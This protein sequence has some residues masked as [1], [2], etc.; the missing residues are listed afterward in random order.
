MRLHS[1][2]R[3]VLYFAIT[4]AMSNCSF[5]NK[6]TVTEPS[7]SLSSTDSTTTTTTTTTVT[8]TSSTTTTTVPVVISGPLP[9]QNA[10]SVSITIPSTTFS[11]PFYVGTSGTPTIRVSG[12]NAGNRVRLYIW[13]LN[14]GVYTCVTNSGEGVSTGSSVDITISPGLNASGSFAI[15]PIAD[16][17]AGNNTGCPSVANYPAIPIVLYS[18]QG[19]PAKPTSLTL[20]SPTTNTRAS[21]I[22]VR[23]GGVTSGNTVKIYSDSNCT[24]QIG[25]AT[26]S[27]TTVNIT[28]T[29]NLPSGSNTIY[30]N[31]TTAS[32]T[33]ACSTATLTY[34]RSATISA[35]SSIALVNTISSSDSVA[36]PTLTVLGVVSGDTVELYTD[37]SCSTL[38]ASGTAS[39]TT[40]DLTTTNPLN[41]G[42]YNFYAKSKFTNTNVDSTTTVLSSTCSSAHTQYILN[43]FISSPTALSVVSPVTVPSLSVTP[44]VRVSG[45]SNGDTVYLFNDSSCTSQIASTTA[46]GSTVDILTSL[47]AGDA[48]WDFYSTRINGNMHSPC[49]SATAQYL[50][51][52]GASISIDDIV[53]SSMEGTG[54]HNITCRS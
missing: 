38:V 24:T 48:T 51:D 10:M 25:S 31:Q 5:K 47:P 49:S 12:V 40:I 50:V 54:S 35:P 26:A 18:Y 33:S 42:T 32:G 14:V 39:G 17:G 6:E 27:S 29:V 3:A 4:I 11:N 52:Q 1:L 23:V 37:S 19:P 44:I 7:I 28:T 53:G 21:V 15:V 22:T 36:S 8:T 9:A 16:D 46:T 30:A 41:D 34:T 45:V 20:I 2:T 13:D 43:T